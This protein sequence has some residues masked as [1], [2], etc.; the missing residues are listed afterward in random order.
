MICSCRHEAVSLS[1]SAAEV[2]NVYVE[3]SDRAARNTDAR[4]ASAELIWREPGNPAFIRGTAALIH[5]RIFGKVA[6]IQGVAQH[7]FGDL[8][9]HPFPKAV[10]I[11]IV[12]DVVGLGFSRNPSALLQ[13]AF[14]LPQ[15]A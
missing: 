5:R 2:E 6:D 11:F 15:P 9:A 8:F 14:Q 10:L 13:F 7:V 12:K 1:S 4:A 3:D